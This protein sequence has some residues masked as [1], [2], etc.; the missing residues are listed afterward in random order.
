MIYKNLIVVV[1]LVSSFYLLFFFGMNFCLVG[2]N[3]SSK[4]GLSE[5]RRKFWKPDAWNPSLSS[6][7]IIQNLGVGIE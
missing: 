6:P 3:Y 1:P 4:E 5:S 7:R 2:L